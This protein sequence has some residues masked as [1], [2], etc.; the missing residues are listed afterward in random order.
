MIPAMQPVRTP[1]SQAATRGAGMLRV[2]IVTESFL[3][4]M[5]GVARSVVSV[6]DELRA[7]GHAVTVIA[8]APGPDRYGTT[9]VVRLPSLPLPWTPSFPLGVP[10]SRLRA[11]LRGLRPD[12]VHLASP[13]LLGA[14]AASVCR[15]L[16]LPTV[17]VYQTDLAGFAGEHGLGG[18]RG[19]LWRWLRAVH[20]DC[21]LTL[22][23]SRAAIADLR[24]HGIDRLA[25]WGR[26]VDRH[27]FAPW[28]RTRPA[29]DRVDRVRI[30]YVGRLAQEKRLD[31]L[32]LLIDLPG[33]E[34]VVV[35]DG[36]ERAALQRLL[37]TASF[38]GELRGPALS[39]A[40]ADLDVFV[41]TG[42]HETFCQAV[43]EAL[44]SGVPVV[45]PA[46]GGPLD[47]VRHGRNGLLW[48]PH[49]PASL[50]HAVRRLVDDPQLRRRQGLAARR[51]VADRTWSVLCDEL[52]DHYR[53]VLPARAG[54]TRT[55][56]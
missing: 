27:A 51:D 17:A 28:H 10:T 49:R 29:T 33:T 48:D 36:D 20:N 18:T 13:V 4:A 53:S 8:P 24:T 46:R 26:G 23:P 41:H 45:A 5:N 11:T 1:R 34:V 43:Q 40:Y 31:R 39:R 15:E 42:V 55:A 6:V 30:G 2:V 38:T 47:L 3:P 7:R 9:P 19:V 52:L 54:T 44:A 32:H 22:A 37:P 50:R 14:R 16:P 25:R 35:G 12:V 21:S 56:A